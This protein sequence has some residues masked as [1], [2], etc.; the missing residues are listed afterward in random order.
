[1]IQIKNLRARFGIKY[2]EDLSIHPNQCIAVVGPNGAG[3]STFLRLL[4]GR[5]SPVKGAVTIDGIQTD[6]MT[7]R[8][9]LNHMSYLPSNETL[10]PGLTVFDSV[11]LGLHATQNV[12]AVLSDT[13]KA[14][15]KHALQRV[16][17]ADKWNSPVR[18]LSSGEY[19]R[20]RLARLFIQAA[21]IMILDE[22][23]AFLDPHQALNLMET[24]GELKTEGKTIIMSLHQLNHAARSC[25]RIIVIDEGHVVL[26]EDARTTL[27]SDV[28]RTVFGV[29]FV[30]I[31]HPHSQKT[32]LLLPNEMESSRHD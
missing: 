9:R 6:Q 32:H 30:S 23:F 4:F 21:P 18:A 29:D 7:V 13:Q 5:L 3:K 25:D 10:T 22:P 15:I 27:N 26:S 31:T 12:F 28:L 2:I 24:F 1:M 16:S 14:N 8:Q 11:A 19:Q 20:V 17:L